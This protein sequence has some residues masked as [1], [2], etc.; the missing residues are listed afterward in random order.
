M[1]D[2]NATYVYKCALCPEL[3]PDRGMA[4]SVVNILIPSTL[5]VSSHQRIDALAQQA[6]DVIV[7]QRTIARSVES[8]TLIFHQ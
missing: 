8:P 2:Y 7:H 5:D 1:I 4:S 3:N 6:A